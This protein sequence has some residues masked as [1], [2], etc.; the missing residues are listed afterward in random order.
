[1]AIIFSSE[2]FKSIFGS[3]LKSFRRFPLTLLCSLVATVCVILIAKDEVHS[4]VL[5]KIAVTF[6]LFLPMFFSAEIFEERKQTP[7]FLILGLSVLAILTFYFLG[8]PEVVD[9]F[10]NKSFLIRL[11]VLVIVFHLLVSVAPYI[12]TKNSSG[13]WQYNKTLLINILTAFLYTFTLSAGLVLAVSG[14]QNL[15]E[16]KLV[17][18][19]FVYIW[20]GV[21]GFFNTLIFTSKLPALEQIDKETSYPLGLKFFTQYVLLPLVAIFLAILLA[22][23]GKIILAWSLPKGLVSIMVLASAIFG[24]LAFLLIYPLKNLNNWIHS[25]NKAY[26][27]ILIP[28]VG[29]MLV[30]I[31]VRISQYGLTEP[32]Y[33]VAMLAVWMLGIAIYFSFSKV[34]NIKI[35]PLSLLLLGLIGIFAPYNAFQSSRTNQIGRMKEVLIKNKLLKAGKI[36]VPFNFTLDS[37]NQDRL[38]AA[39][40]YLAESHPGNL[41]DYLTEKQF[42]ELTAEKNDFQRAQLIYKLINLP[43]KKSFDIYKYFSVKRPSFYDLNKADFFVDSREH[44]GEKGA[45]I[46]EKDS[47]SWKLEQDILTFIIGKKEKVNF[48]INKLKNENSTE[49]GIESTTFELET[50]KFSMKLLI[51][52]G[53]SNNGILENLQWKLFLT[54]K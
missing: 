27:W 16:V 3:F 53:N 48:D 36:I 11:G 24:I 35:I 31:Y 52:S 37:M 22:Y 26:Y 9:I 8:F 23:E 41:K 33:F 6:G 43:Q 38:Y 25:Y 21:N 7:R 40:E 49:L 42:D 28:L 32:R 5:E 45:I 20:F 44:G 51:E 4:K 19:W 14:V 1:M 50:T 13:F 30:A 54:N 12:F 39:L 47:L 46:I 17:D 29:L 15:F 10:N 34:D 2:N 18:D